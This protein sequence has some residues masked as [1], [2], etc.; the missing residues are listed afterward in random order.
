MRNTRSAHQRL[1]IFVMCAQMVV[2][3]GAMAAYGSAGSYSK[4]K[5]P[6]TGQITNYSSTFGEDSD[7][8]SNLPSFTINGDGTVTDNIT[9]LMWQ[10]A[11]GGE[12][13]IERAVIYCDT[14]KLGQYSDWR[15]PTSHELFGIVNHDR[16]NPALDTL[17][18]VKT[19]AEYWWSAD[20]RIGDSSKV[21]VVNSGGGIGPHP[22]TETRSA[23]G[24]KLFHV[25]SVREVSPAA[26]TEMRFRNNGDSTVT[27]LATG[28]MWQKYQP[29]AA[30][31]WELALNYAESLSM[32]GYGDW[33]LPNVKEMQ[34]LNDE[35]IS[36][37]SVDQSFFPAFAS[38][39]CWS[40]TTQFNATTRAWYLDFAYGIASYELKTASLRV[41]CVRGESRLDADTISEALIPGGEFA[42]GDHFGFVDP[43]HPS[44][45]L[46]IH[47]VKV[48]SFF[49]A[50]TET[51]NEQVVALLNAAHV[52]GLI[53]VRG[54]CVFMSGGTDTLL[55]LNGFAAYSSI[56]WNGSTFS[57]ADFRANHPVVGVKW[58]GAAA[59]C[60]WLSDQQALGRCYDSTS[61]KCDFTA[62]GYRLPTEAEWEYAARGGHTNP[63]YN[64]P[65]G[66]DQDVTKANWPG[67][68]DPYETGDFP[69]TTPVGFYDGSLRLKVEFN[70]PGT[71]SSYQT[72]N[73]A[74]DFGLFDMAGNVWEFVN[75]WYG[76]AYYSVSP[77]DNPK[78]PDSGSVMPDGKRYRG[79]RGGNWYNGYTT[80]SVNDGHSRVSN[81]NPSYYRGP[82][83]PNHPWYHIGFRVARNVPGV[84]GVEEGVHE[85][86]G[87]FHLQQNYPNPFNPVTRIRYEVASLPAGQAGR[88]QPAVSN[89]RL[90]VYDL[91]GRE[92]AVLVNE[93]KEPG[94]YEVQ[95][96]AASMCSGVYYC[97]LELGSRVETRKM[98]LIK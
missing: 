96:N 76:N 12:M 22:M 63:Y 41:L 81:R 7:Y 46:P 57:V 68:G 71:Q 30:M 73:G 13:T 31:N 15:L 51:S 52:K 65:W 11:D 20:R 54:N 34:S 23:G 80:T 27:D 98:M 8:L 43:S 55:L 82:L 25:R 37:P 1:I 4:R 2:A 64:Y 45:E 40:S 83:D 89:V 9:G 88:Q 18:F 84:S 78:G 91:L 53:E 50:R 74:N 14:L 47:T 21:W 58:T 6:D 16:L 94:S 72:S 90:A 28:L 3:Q 97:R 42:M 35:A 32:A 75:D 49:M 86:P 39:K 17:T 19:A 69:Y 26:A 62:S 77:Y 70:W 5:L 36:N 38:E 61:W 92:V 56:G 93:Q 10:Q 66:N 48:N 60:N 24:A 29:P 59:L 79:M 44:D 95:W 67:S 87:E 85:A 33:R